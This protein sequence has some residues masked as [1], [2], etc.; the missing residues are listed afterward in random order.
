VN[1]GQ[2][3]GGFP[4]TR[5]AKLDDGLFDFLHVADVRRW[6]LLRYLPGLILG[7]LPLGHAKIQTGTTSRVH[8]TSANPLCVH[9]DGE[10]VCQ[11]LDGVTELTFEMLPQKLM[12]EAV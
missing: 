5:G 10:F 2:K 12:V 3:E 6:E 9:A 1:I 11:P 7:R 8:L 4:I